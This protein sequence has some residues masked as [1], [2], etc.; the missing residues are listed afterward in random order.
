MILL[1]PEKRDYCFGFFPEFCRCFFIVAY[2]GVSFKFGKEYNVSKWEGVAAPNCFFL[3]S[4]L[5]F[6]M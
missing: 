4:G 5:N 1:K 6:V 2:I 3:T